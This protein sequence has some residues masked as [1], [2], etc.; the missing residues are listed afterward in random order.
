VLIV[1]DGRFS[2]MK[3][4]SVPAQQKPYLP[5][6]EVCATQQK[7]FELGDQEGTLIGFYC[8]SYMAGFEAVGF[9]LHFLNSSHNAGGHVIDFAVTDGKL[10]LQMITGFQAILPGLESS[11]AESD[12]EPPSGNPAPVKTP[13][14]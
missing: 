11:F 2:H 1:V 4:R 10:R 5:L 8:P 3:T 6:G 7:F 9:H 14:E 13:G 12:I